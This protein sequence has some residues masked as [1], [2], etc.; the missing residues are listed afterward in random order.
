[1]LALSN[2]INKNEINNWTFI[3][4]IFFFNHLSLSH[5]FLIYHLS[6]FI[7]WAKKRT[8]DN[9]NRIKRYWRRNSVAKVESLFWIS[10]QIKQFIFCGAKITK[11]I[12]KIDFYLLSSANFRTWQKNQKTIFPNWHV[13]LFLIQNQIY[14]NWNKKN[15]EKD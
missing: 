1:M 6:M 4:F 11:W 9:N 13:L 10:D 5:Y 2:I 15:K 14:F 8:N 3:I 7:K 12:K